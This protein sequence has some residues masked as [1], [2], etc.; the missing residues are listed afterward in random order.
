MT[1][2]M[3]VG[4]AGASW[5][6]TL[7]DALILA[8]RNS[9]LL[10]QNRALLRAADEDVAQA[11]ASLRPVLAF[12]ADA[13]YADNGI[14]AADFSASVA[15]QASLDIYDGG[16]NRIAI[17]SAK[18]SVLS[19]R[20]S[21]ISVEQQVLLS[22]VEAYMAVRSANE[23]VALGQNNVRLITE[24]LRAAK[25][26]FEVGD[27]T[28]T[29]VSL[30]E[31][32]LATAQSNLVAGQGALAAAREAYKLVIGDYPGTLSGI[33]R[34]PDLPDSLDEARALA[35]R[36]HPDIDAQQRSVKV[37]EFTLL[38][39]RAAR[40]PSL[41][42]TARLS[43]SDGGVNSNSVGLTLNQTLYSGGALKSVERQALAALEASQSG[44][45]RSVRLVEQ[46]V[47]NSWA[48][49]AVSTA[50]ILASDQRIRAAQ[51]AFDGTKEEARLGAR[52]TLDVL[53]AEQEL[54]DARTDRIQAE[55]DRIVAIY[56]VLASMGLLTVEHLN[57][58]IPTYD[59]A[60]Y[61]NS[62][63]NAPISSPQGDKLDRVLKAIGQN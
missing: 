4:S 13:G 27:V 36:T 12:I 48:D 49:L 62:V 43:A 60:D 50:Q 45:H 19:T 63:K 35:V 11:V 38:R 8:Y 18:E 41:S 28:R 44:L 20:A 31:S 24:Q 5:A 54:L 21:L 16:A 25:D 9:D 29:D 46:E 14:T 57:L 42:A 47:G 58:G 15:L 37:S 53:D 23:T 56:A 52:T 26:R 55:N 10:E 33:A 7:T 17:D 6:E 40:G 22:A 61:Y 3:A 1:A 51:L 2:M 39:A 30:A 34:L 59:P 32:R